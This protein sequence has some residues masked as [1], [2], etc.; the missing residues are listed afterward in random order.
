MMGSRRLHLVDRDVRK[1]GRHPVERRLVVQGVET[2]H[3]MFWHSWLNH[4]KI[5][6]TFMC[7]LSYFCVL[8]LTCYN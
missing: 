1:R 5:S 2:K 8:A 7:G 3:E 6:Y 4:V